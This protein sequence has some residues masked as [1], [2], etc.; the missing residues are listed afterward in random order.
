M[1]DPKVPE[2]EVHAAPANVIAVNQDEPKEPEYDPDDLASYAASL[3]DDQEKVMQLEGRNVRIKQPKLGHPLVDEVWKMFRKK[4]KIQ[5]EGGKEAVQD[6]HVLTMRIAATSIRACLVD[7]K[8]K[9]LD[10]DQWVA[11]INASE[12]G[13]KLALQCEA[14]CIDAIKGMPK[15]SPT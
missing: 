15:A 12:D 3:M 7:E 8:Q 10:E 5:A 11:M 13:I 1:E 9:E 4:D 6:N 2:T 14:M